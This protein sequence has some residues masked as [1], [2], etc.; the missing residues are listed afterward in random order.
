VYTFGASI[1]VGALTA[2]WLADREAKRVGM[3][4]DQVSTL[5]LIL[6]IAGLLG[7]RIFFVMFYDP[8]YYWQHPLDIF[9]IY[10]GGLS[11]HGGILGGILAGLWYSKRTDI[12]FWAVADILAPAALLA[13][14]I[15]RV[16]CDVYGKVMAQAWSWGVQVQG[17]IVHP[18]QV[19]E[20]LLDLALFIFLWGKR[21]RQ[22]YSGQIFVYY[23]GGYALIRLIL[24]F[25]RVNPVL[26]GIL[27]PAHL[28]SILFIIA[29]MVLARWRSRQEL[30]T[31]EAQPATPHWVSPGVWA[32]VTL[33][34]TISVAVFYGMNG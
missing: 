19:Y 16:G 17:Q 34:A 18:V 1:A 5:S 21:E 23:L 10:E 7:A 33:L 32:A 11:I 2:F 20:T 9:K 6:L 8:T 30:F 29:A 12:S 3:D 27:T 13:Q 22:R 31:I 25:F 15:A 26:I 14:G 24:E 28:T 4:A